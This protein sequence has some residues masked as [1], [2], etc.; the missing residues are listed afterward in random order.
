MVEPD[1]LVADF[2]SNAEFTCKAYLAAKTTSS[3]ND[4]D[5]QNSQGEEAI[6]G[7]TPYCQQH[8]INISI[9]FI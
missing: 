6:F 8:I 5:Q 3:A 4:E 2:G 7:L 1:L 9:S